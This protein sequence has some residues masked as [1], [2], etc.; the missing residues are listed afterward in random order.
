MAKEYGTV[1]FTKATSAV[2]TFRN[3]MCYVLHV[4]GVRDIQAP[5]RLIEYEGI[6]LVKDLAN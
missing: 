2:L 6:E 1:Q 3:G 5:S 4:C